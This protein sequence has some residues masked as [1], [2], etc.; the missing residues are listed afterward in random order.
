MS[1]GEDVSGFNIV[2]EPPIALKRS[3]ID[4]G[5]ERANGQSSSREVFS[6]VEIDSS[7]NLNSFYTRLKQRG[8]VPKHLSNKGRDSFFFCQKK[9]LIIANQN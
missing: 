5:M 7:L 1:R 6:F 2:F 9:T 8:H 3:S 4:P